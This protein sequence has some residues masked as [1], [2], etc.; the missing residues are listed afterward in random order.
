MMRKLGGLL[1]A[2]ALAAL[3]LAC[4]A[5]S[6]PSWTPESVTVVA[7]RCNSGGYTENT[8]I[9]CV[10]AAA[11]GA[12]VLDVDVRWTRTGLPVL[13]HDPTMGIFGAPSVRIDT[14]SHPE[15]ARYLSPKF[16]NITTLTQLRDTVI[17]SDATVVLEP[18]VTLTAARWQQ[19]DDRFRTIKHRTIINSYSATALQQPHADGYQTRLN[20]N[21]DVDTL[22]AGVDG[23]VIP[24]AVIRAPVPPNT[25]CDHAPEPTEWQKCL[26]AGTETIVTD[27]HVALREWLEEA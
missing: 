26:D 2:L 15:A 3:A 7:H 23:V 25:W 6:A 19:I 16:N 4:L 24:A 27:N 22:P 13:L 20:V 21:A 11:S 17:A 8:Q 1:A 12:D 14:L 10:H 18:K 5:G 9:G